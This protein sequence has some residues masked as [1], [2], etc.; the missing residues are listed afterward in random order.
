MYVFSAKNVSK[1]FVFIWFPSTDR[2]MVEIQGNPPAKPVGGSAPAF[3][4]CIPLSQ[5]NELKPQHFIAQPSQCV[6]D[7]PRLAN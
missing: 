1:V 3:T 5:T 4:Q 2:Q 7:S 6:K